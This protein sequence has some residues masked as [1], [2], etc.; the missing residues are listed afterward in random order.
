MTE[1]DYSGI[2]EYISFRFQEDTI[3]RKVETT[4][5]RIQTVSYC[6][7]KLRHTLQVFKSLVVI[8]N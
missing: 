2:Y 1:T 7:S 6:V 3:F 5:K 8:L 4:L